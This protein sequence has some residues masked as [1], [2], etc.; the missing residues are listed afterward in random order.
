[1]LIVKKADG[2]S[3][4]NLIRT[5]KIILAEFGLPKKIV[6]DAGMNFISDQLKHFL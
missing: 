4:D 2:L 6:S 5:A 3:S 1:M